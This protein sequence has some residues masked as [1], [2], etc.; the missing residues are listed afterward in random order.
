MIRFA[1]NVVSDHWATAS[2]RVSVRRK[3]ARCR[4]SLSVPGRIP[5]WTS[6]WTKYFSS[7]R[8]SRWLGR[9]SLA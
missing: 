6:T 4:P 1:R 9:P 3:L 5:E 8:R 2:G 7:R